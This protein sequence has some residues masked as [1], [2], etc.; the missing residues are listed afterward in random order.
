MKDTDLM[1][2]GKYKGLRLANVPP[3]YFLWLHD[4][5]CSHAGVKAY[6]ETNIEVFKAEL[7][8][9]NANTGNRH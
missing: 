7:K 2:F 6:I 1:P 8:Q 4:Q 3:E 5:G 9:N